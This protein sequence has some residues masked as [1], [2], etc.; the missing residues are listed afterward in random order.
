[1]A[2]VLKLVKRKPEPKQVTTNFQAGEILYTK[3]C[4][5]CHGPDRMGTGDNPSLIGVGQKYSLDEFQ[6]LVSTG[7]RMMPG[8]PQ[9]SKEEKVALGAYIL[10][11]ESKKEDEYLLESDKMPKEIP[12]SAPQYGFTGYNKFLTKD[13]YPAIAPPWG[14]L[15][16]INLNTGELVW[17]IPFGEYEELSKKGIPVTGRENYGGPVVTAGGLIFV[18]AT[19][20]GKFRAIN[21]NNGKILF[22]TD[23]PA[24]GVAT[25]AV[26]KAGN[27]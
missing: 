18:V 6:D 15:S 21:K 27:K 26:Y 16:A 24:P 5:G 14:T 9:I 8:F 3:Y 19:A 20:D 7:R 11:I 4:M 12:I 13:G 23:L 25:P 17:K 22:E 10:N 1:M 2:W